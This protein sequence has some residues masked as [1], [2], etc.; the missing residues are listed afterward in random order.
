MVIFLEILKLFLQISLEKGGGGAEY[1]TKL[2]LFH[3]EKS[4]V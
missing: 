4:L 2:L 1:L 3:L